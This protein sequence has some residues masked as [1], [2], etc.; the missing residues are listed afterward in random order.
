MRKIVIFDFAGTLVC[1]RPATLLIPRF[2]LNVLSW[3]FVL[4][5][6]T[7]ASR[8]DTIRILHKLRIVRFF[9]KETIVTKDDSSYRKP[10]IRLIQFFAN[11]FKGKTIWLYVGDG[12]KD[13]K[14]AKRY[15]INFLCYNFFNGT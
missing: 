15:K 9:S 7:G 10:D 3:F 13:F 1:M 14:M 11:K 2:I 4:G 5:I 12:I 8:K 6:I